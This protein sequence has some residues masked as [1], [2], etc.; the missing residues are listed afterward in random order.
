M[1]REQA[2]DRAVDA[3]AVAAGAAVRVCTR[4]GAAVAE[5]AAAYPSAAGL[6]VGAKFYDARLYLF[7]PVEEGR[8]GTE[9]IPLAQPTHDRDLGYGMCPICGRPFVRACRC[10]QKKH[11]LDEL[12]KGHGFECLSGH[13]VSGD[14]AVDD[15]GKQIDVPKREDVHARAPEL[16]EARK[17]DKKPK[18]GKLD[19][20]ALPDDVRAAVTVDHD[21]TEEQVQRVL[22]AVG[23][24]ALKALKGAGVREDAVY[25]RVAAI[26]EAVRPV[27]E[28]DVGKAETAKEGAARVKAAAK[29]KGADAEEDE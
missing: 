11:T 3:S 6:C 15:K 8:A 29:A 22:A 13:W 12:R 25:A 16:S 14:L 4:M 5:G 9:R 27:L 28:G 18:L 17:G 19:P 21:M 2:A 20:E 24:A 7:Q 1:G 26:Q 23:D 10:P